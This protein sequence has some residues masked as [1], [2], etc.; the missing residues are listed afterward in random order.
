M[1]PLIKDVKRNYAKSHRKKVDDC[2]ATIARWQRKH[3]IATNKLETAWKEL[4]ALSKG[5]AELLDKH[6]LPPVHENP[7]AKA[8]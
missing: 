5:H 8:E 6:S 3:T 1:D 7:P 2:L 4:L